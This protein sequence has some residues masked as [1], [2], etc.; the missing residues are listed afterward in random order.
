MNDL[1]AILDAFKV[2]SQRG[3]NAFLVTVVNTQGSTYRRPGAR[4][5]ITQTG[6]M[7]GMVSGGCLEQDILEH[8]KDVGG[9]ALVVTYDSTSDEDILWGFGLGCNGVVQVLIESLQ[10]SCNPLTILSECWHERCPAVLASIFQTEGQVEGTTVGLGAC[11]ALT[12]NKLIVFAQTNSDLV[13]AIGA[14][15]QTVLYQQ[16]S[17]IKSYDLST[18]KVQVF[19]EFIQSP[20]SIMIFGAGQDAIPVAQLAKSLGWQVTVTD[21]RA[22]PV[23]NERFAMADQVILTVVSQEQGKW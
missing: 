21:C 9:E 15:A 1:Q 8:T 6:E 3:E 7:I 5:L 12:P 4:I 13:T 11:L 2:A 20:T 17:I 22:N 23:S 10:P 14:D 18:G 19:L 16:Q